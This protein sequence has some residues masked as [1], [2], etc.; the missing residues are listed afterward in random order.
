MGSPRVLELAVVGLVALWMPIVV[1]AVF[2][3]IT[4]VISHMLPGWHRSDMTAVPGEDKLLE[5]LRELH[6][7][8]GEYRFPYGA[9]TEE[10]TNPAF[11]EKMNLGPVGTMTVRPNGE[12]PMGRMLGQWFLYALCVAVLVAYVT[13]L[14]HGP[15]APFRGVL[16]VSS[17]VAFCCYAVAHWQNWIWWGKGTRFTLTHTVDGLA[18]GLVT[19]ATFGWLWPG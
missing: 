1:S 12:L 14:T 15:G 3:A 11:V 17:T 2:C 5:T 8:P 18:Y 6:V 9:T 10:M 7:P 19:G 4:L 16:R 13:G